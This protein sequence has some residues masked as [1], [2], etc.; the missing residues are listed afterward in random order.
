[1][2][3]GSGDMMAPTSGSTGKQVSHTVGMLEEVKRS[4]NKVAAKMPQDSSQIEGR[5]ME[6]ESPVSPEP[7]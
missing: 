3:A 1:M 2:M 5:Y 6:F 7:K 4:K